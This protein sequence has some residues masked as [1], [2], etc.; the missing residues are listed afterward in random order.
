MPPDGGA[1]LTAASSMFF[2]GWEPIGRVVL[3]ATLAYAA[4]VAA[5][6]VAG[7]RA[8]AKMSAYD[9][10]I[11]IALGSL[12]ASVPLQQSVTLAEGLAA[13]GTFLLL[14]RLVSLLAS[15]WRASRAVAKASPTLVL[16]DGRLLRDRM[17]DIPVTDAEVHAALRSSGMGSPAQA[18]AVVLEN[19]GSWSVIGRGQAGDLSALRELDLPASREGREGGGGRPAEGGPPPPGVTCPGG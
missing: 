16:W 8:L 13:I 15:R 5:L 14:Q 17:R 9:L 7:S 6:R 4:L 1:A 11:T 10:V 19:D 12:I 18:Q 2:D 3:M